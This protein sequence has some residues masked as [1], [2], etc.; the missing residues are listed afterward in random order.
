MVVEGWVVGVVEGWV[1]GA[2]DVVVVV[3]VVAVVVLVE[4]WTKTSLVGYCVPANGFCMGV[5]EG[6]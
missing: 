6:V 5:E 2:V 1:V 3:V 4:G